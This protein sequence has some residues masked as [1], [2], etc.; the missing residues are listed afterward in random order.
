MLHLGSFKVH[1]NLNLIISLTFLTLR[2]KTEAKPNFLSGKIR[3][4]IGRCSRLI[5]KLVSYDSIECY[6]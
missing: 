6:L 1:I 4:T 2:Q 5:N 3:Y